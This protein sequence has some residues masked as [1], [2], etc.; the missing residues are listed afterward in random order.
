MT[1]LIGTPSGLYCGPPD[2]PERT[3]E[4]AVNQVET[5][6][7]VALAAT[8]DGLYRS[9]DGHEWEQF[10]VYGRS[11]MAV[12]REPGGDRT[13]VGTMPAAIYYTDDW[14]RWRRC[15]AVGSLPSRDRWRE[16]ARR[17]DAQI[18]AFA[19][20]P[21]APDRVLAG[22]ESGG[23]IVS[24]DR[25]GNWEE[26]TLGVHD[27]VH[28]LLALD[29]DSYVVGTGNGLYRTSDTGE[30]WVRLDTDHR[31]FWYNYHRESIVHE[32]TFHTAALAMGRED[33]RQRGF[34]YRGAVDG[35]GRSFERVD[36]P[37]NDEAFVVSFVEDGELLAG[38][39]R[40]RNGFESRQPARILRRTDDGWRSIGT[41]PAAASSMA[42]L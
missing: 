42:I 39:M 20:H 18:R 13:Y 31:D 37:G 19:T 14:E 7:G 27:D 34:L 26:R 1:L 11:V 32:G 6:D 5:V 15:D 36:H 40:V 17:R 16:R 30:S 24:E 23:V 2:D 21:D 38:T 41:V 3:L 28:H 8:D 22:V 33:L 4:A 35:D 10:D 29:A 25:G 9:T 12:T